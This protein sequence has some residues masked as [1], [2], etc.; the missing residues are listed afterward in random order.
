MIEVKNLNKTFAQSGGVK[1]LHDVSLKAYPGEVYGFLGHNGAGKTTTMQILCGLSPYDSGSIALSSKAIG[2]V[3]ENPM[4]YD[5]LSLMEYLS[6]IAH[7]TAK[8]A[9]K[10]T[11]KSVSN[12]NLEALCEVVGLSKFK[13]KRIIR[14]SRGMKQRAAIAAALINDPDILLLDEPTSALDPEGRVDVMAIIQNLKNQG[15]TILLSTH[16]LSDVEN[17]CDRVGILKEGH[18]LYEDHVANLHA[19]HAQSAIDIQWSQTETDTF[20][21]DA[22]LVEAFHKI[23]KIELI[24]NGLSVHVAHVQQ[25]MQNVLNLLANRDTPC[26]S[27]S[28]KKLK[29]ED[30]Y[31]GFEREVKHD[32]G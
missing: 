10:S 16:I 32:L 24:P 2:F 7:S 30:I 19:L 18:M 11:S 15:K 23:G 27:V 13:R 25:G 29:L 1:V 28:I 12:Q 21:P 9:S 4:F 17:V 14:F 3:P 31:M 20:T 5:T 22:H 26:A 8:S 6:L